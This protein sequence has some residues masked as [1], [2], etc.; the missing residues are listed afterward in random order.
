MKLNKGFLWSFLYFVVSVGASV[1]AIFVEKSF[2]IKNSLLGPANVLLYLSIFTVLVS[3]V[4]SIM[5]FNNNDKPGFIMGMIGATLCAI[6][7]VVS[8]ALFINF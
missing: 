6:V 2:P 8:I 7:L 4:H 3:V 1:A 5:L